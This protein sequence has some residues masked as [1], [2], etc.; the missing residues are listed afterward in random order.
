M[1]AD[2]LAE[3]E[4]DGK[5]MKRRKVSNFMC[6][7]GQ[8]KKQYGSLDALNLH[9]KNKHPKEFLQFRGLGKKKCAHRQRKVLGEESQKLT[10]T[11][12]NN[13]VKVTVES[14]AQESTP[15]SK[16]ESCLNF[17]YL[18]SFND[19]AEESSGCEG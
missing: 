13:V 18:K 12:V 8:C 5:K 17:D 11:T 7:V 2:F 4:N 16:A 14:L 9:M 10:I 15:N 19:K 6:S 1:F 3:D